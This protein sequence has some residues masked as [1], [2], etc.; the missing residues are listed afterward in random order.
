MK[1]NKKLQTTAS[2]RS[3]AV[4]ARGGRT[5]PLRRRT[6]G[7]SLIELMLA[8]TL[9]LVVTAGIVQLFVGN[10]RTNQLITGQS[11]LQESARYALDFISTS[12]RNAGFYGCDPERDKLYNSLN[13]N[14]EQ[15]FELNLRIPVQ[16]FDGSGSGT[17]VGDWTPSLMNLPRNSSGGGGS[18]NAIVDGNGIDISTLVPGTDILVV[19]Y[20][21][22]PGYR[23]AQQI[24]AFEDPVIENTGDVD[25]APGDYAV[26]SNCE[27]AAIF[28]ITGVGGG[29]EL[30]LSRGSGLGLY[31]NSPTGSLSEQG[32]SYGSDAL[33]NNQGSVVSEILTDIY[34][35]AQSSNLN[36]RGEN[37]TSL[38]R[39]SGTDAPIEMVEGISDLQ[40]LFGIDSTRN[41]GV[42][43]AN[44]YVTYAGVGASIIRSVRVSIEANTVD[45]VSES[46]EP[47]SRTFTQTIS[48]RNSEG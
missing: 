4:I 24:D 28:N 45:V 15:V 30:T 33:S 42:A 31:A 18:V 13:A 16:G 35:V 29:A 2:V 26:I 48:L 21:V 11:R 8:L 14:W 44:R 22:A 10:N 12:T 43:G 37:I 46:P 27:Q 9:G 38:W 47:I 34:F 39:K 23:V 6:Q 5:Q 36:N 32:I 7:F 41:N 20:Q 3:G 19:R 1:S 40:V 25:F 17:G